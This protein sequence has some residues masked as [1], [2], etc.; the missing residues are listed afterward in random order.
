MMQS[1]QNLSFE[2]RHEW[3]RLP[4]ILLLGSI[5]AL[6]MGAA[7]YFHV[8][9]KTNVL[10]DIEAQ[11]DIFKGNFQ[12]KYRQVQSLEGL[13]VQKRLVEDQIHTLENLLPNKTEMDKLLAD[14]NQVG[15]KRNLNFELFKPGAPDIKDYYAQIPLNI[16][17]KGRYHD[18]AAFMS[19]VAGLP[20]IVNS[21]KFKLQEFSKAGG[22]KVASGSDILLMDGVLSTY[23]LLDEDEKKAAQAKN[24]IK[25]AQPAAGKSQPH[26]A[27]EE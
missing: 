15:L 22:V 24:K 5:A 27:N 6:V 2:E 18:I 8:A 11:E 17:L 19:D 1:L 20:R 10:K 21:E 7:W 23:R 26:K 4:K 3:P 14:I 12:D 13:K 16:K 25:F 9:Q